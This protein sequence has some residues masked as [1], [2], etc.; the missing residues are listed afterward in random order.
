MMVAETFRR[1]RKITSTT[2]QTVSS[3]VNLTSCDRVA[4]RDGAI[5][6][7][8]ERDGGRQL[9]AEGRQ[10]LLDRVDDRH[11]VRARL[12]EDRKEDGSARR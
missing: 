5:G 7:D 8:V 12:L 2:R 3:S 11:D 1:N 4:N 6:A 10:Q 9:L